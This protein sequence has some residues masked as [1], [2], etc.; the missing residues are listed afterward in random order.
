MLLPVFY[1]TGVVR[2]KYLRIYAH[3]IMRNYSTSGR[4]DGSL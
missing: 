3:T 2:E 4:A 1:R